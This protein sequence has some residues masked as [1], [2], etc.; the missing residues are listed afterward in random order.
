MLFLGSCTNKSA[1]VAAFTPGEDVP[2][3]RQV[4]V[5][6]T[7][8]DSAVKKMELRADEALNY[9]QLEEPKLEF[10]KGIDV[11]F[12]DKDEV[13]DSHLRS[14]YAIRFP[15][16]QMWRATGN[17]EVTNKKGERLETELLIWDEKEEII[18]SDAF[19]KMSTGNQVIMGE[20]FRADQNFTSYEI[21]KVT[22]ELYVPDDTDSTDI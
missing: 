22:G 1:E 12:F 11:T 9:P 2:M 18:F 6:L 15:Q 3:E 21:N 10:P 17:V 8:T 13:E 20:G 19:V 14:D 4:N 16:K 5:F 7:Y